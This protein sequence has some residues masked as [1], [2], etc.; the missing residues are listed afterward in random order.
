MPPRISVIIPSCNRRHSLERV[1]QALEAQTAPPASFEV[2]VALDG[3]TD[4]SEE[5]LAG[6]QSN[7]RL[8]GLRF[9]N[10]EN[11]GQAAARSRG[12]L[13]ARTPLLLFLDD[14]VVPEA[15]FIAAHLERHA[16]GEH[17]AVLG[18]APVE[19]RT[20]ESLHHLGVW[21][22]WHD[23]YYTRRQPGGRPGSRDFCSGNVSLRRDDFFAAGGFNPAFRGYG[24]E[25][26]ELGYRLLQ[27][28]VRFVCEPRAA[29]RHHHRSSVAGVLRQTR[30]EAGGDALMARL[31]PELLPGLRLG[32]LPQGSYRYLALLALT[33]PWLGDLAAAL[34]RLFLPVL[35]GAK[36]R[37]MWLRLF[38]HLRGYAYWRGVR[39]EFGSY[40]ALRRFQ[41]QAPPLPVVHLE[42]SGGLPAELPEVWVEGPARLR[43]TWH[44]RPLGELE[45]ETFLAGPLHP[46]LAAWL[47]DKLEARL[48]L[49]LNQELSARPEEL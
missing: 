18:D 1:L 21:A 46:F 17:L 32:S 28:G 30:Q 3:S 34:G 47:A 7:G 13:L 44:G 24:G 27:R 42:I 25:D 15:S 35:E 23:T 43:V 38:N 45:T 16:G 39:Q 8:P 5:L 40:P 2:I 31:H 49:A 14:D 26:Y 6:W 9:F 48:W 33:L 36:L 20:D 37:R 10:Q 11:A 4:G 29:A 41:Q 12:A 22:W 19:R